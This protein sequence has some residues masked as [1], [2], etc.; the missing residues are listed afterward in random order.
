M[1]RVGLPDALAA[2]LDEPHAPT[3]MQA[4]I[5]LLDIAVKAEVD[6]L[7]RRVDAIEARQR[8]PAELDQSCK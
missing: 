6:D 1:V 5:A 7:A 4:A 3:R 2:A 8:L